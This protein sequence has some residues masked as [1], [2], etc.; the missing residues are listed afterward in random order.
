[1][2]GIIGAMD[3]EVAMLRDRMLD[4]RIQTVSGIDFVVGRLEGQSVVLARSGVG[5][6]FASLCAQTMILKFGVRA[7]VNSG[8]AGTLTSDL[9]IGDIAL[10]SAAVQHDMDTT[11]VGD[12]H[13]L[14]SGINVVELP[15]DR[16]IV[17]ELAAVCDE[18]R[19]NYRLGVVASGDQFVSTHER[20]R[21]VRKTFKGV[22][23]EMEAGAIAQVCYV[24]RIP[25]AAIR[26]I[27]D[28]ASGDVHVDYMSFVK[29]AAATS[30]DIALRWLR[31][32]G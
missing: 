24:N 8:V 20:R 31:R 29:S 18:A 22:A 28:E 11:A 15:A 21:W 7:I 12:P 14:I 3:V 27:S 10:A 1:M 5:K 23:V 9:H 26:V 13:G 17:S 6:V 4:A 2:I 19:V 30:S 25:F 16:R 32:L